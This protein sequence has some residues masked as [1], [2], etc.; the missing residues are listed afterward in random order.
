MHQ[1]IFGSVDYKL[2][3]HKTK[4]YYELN[5]LIQKNCKEK[6]KEKNARKSVEIN[7]V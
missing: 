2:P 6:N 7:N 4:Y 1:A 5:F 3:A